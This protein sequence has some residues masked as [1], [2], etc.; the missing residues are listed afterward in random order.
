MNTFISDVNASLN[1]ARKEWGW[2]LAV[3]LLLVAL[4]VAAF[5][6]QPASTIAS[7]IVLGSIVFTAGI[8]QLFLAFQARGAGHVIL[9]LIIAVLDV[10][11]GFALIEHPA[12]G[13]LLVT[14]MLAVYFVFS[15]A[16]RIIYALW[17]E[18]PQYGWAVLSGI[19]STAL[20]VMLW[21]Q[22][23]VSAIWFIGLAVGVNFIFLGISLSAFAFR[24]RS[25]AS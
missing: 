11:V 25:T 7:V 3:G 23:P 2:F 16:F 13:A 22:W 15:G 9:S 17:A 20:G 1:A 12:A 18:Y 10:V 19:I 5:L 8:L 21:L 6:Y 14:L 24:I 4:G